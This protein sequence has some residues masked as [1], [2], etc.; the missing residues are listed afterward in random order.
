MMNLE[1]LKCV[2]AELDKTLTGGFVN[3]IYQP[4]P[5]EVAFRVYVKGTGELN[6]IAS[7]D[8]RL[9][10]IHLTKTKLPNP[11]NPPRFCA[12]LRAHLRGSLIDSISV[13]DDDR[14]LTIR[15]IKKAAHSLVGRLF[16]LELLGRDSNIILVDEES[17][18][19]MD[20]LLNI[21]EK[22]TATRVVFPGR[23]YA[24]PPK[25]RQR[26]PGNPLSERSPTLKPSI[27]LTDDARRELRL[28]PVSEQDE[29]FATMNEAAD[30]FYSPMIAGMILD[31][32]RRAH[33]APIKK[34]IAS[35]KK[36]MEK[37]AH[38]KQRLQELAYGLEMGELLK[39]NLHKAVKGMTHLEVMDWNGDKKVTIPLDASLDAITN[40]QRIFAKASKGKRGQALVEKRIE[41]TVAEKRALEDLLL[42]LQQAET[43][44]EVSAVLHGIP[45]SHNNLSPRQDHRS[46]VKTKESKCSPDFRHYVSS[47]GL[48]ILVG[49]TGQGNDKILKNK[50]HP[51]DLWFHAK[52]APGAHVIMKTSLGSVVRASDIAKAAS[53]AGYFSTLRKAGKGEIMMTEVR[54]VHSIK[55]GPP[56]KVVVRQYETLIA[57]W[58]IDEL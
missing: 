48:T 1:I 53:L 17:N 46:L 26:M 10:R 24:L 23:L 8:P 35:L 27:V 54:N 4:L 39:A 55:G 32:Y 3:K 5:R 47:S 52:D 50:A 42:L 25:S 11:Q 56:G 33:M 34:R 38:D 45:I 12:Y 15:C 28:F 21:P 14:V 44:D 58:S 22:E 37:I 41:D 7:A 31:N 51:G 19:I 29:T 49:K 30:A 43:V 6:I 9:G 20:C 57:K 2:A 18:T 40:M 13:A 16:I 36:R